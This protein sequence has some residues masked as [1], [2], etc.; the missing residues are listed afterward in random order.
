MTS[1][2]HLPP[3]SS[4]ATKAINHPLSAADQS[5]MA[6]IRKATAAGKGVIERAAFDAV[7]EQTPDAKGVGYETGV[8][9]G[10]SGVW[11]RPLNAAPHAVILYL[12]GGAYIAGT[13]NAFRH[14]SGQIAACTTVAAFV[15]DYRLAPEHHLPTALEDAKAVYSALTNDHANAVAIV[16]DSAGGGL[17]LVLLAVVRSAAEAGKATAPYAGAV[18]SPWTD[19]ALTGASMIERAEADPF[20][21]EAALASAAAQYLHGEDARSSLASPLYGELAGI[22]SLQLHVGTDEILFDDARRYAER[23]QSQHV[24]TTLHVWEGVPHVFQSNVGKLAAAQEALDVLG[25]FLRSHLPREE[26]RR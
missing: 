14:L 17:A 16:G 2:S 5:V 8:V 7:M 6:E 24:E 20:L 26:E 12:H 1:G 23:A 13:A 22:A 21:T 18:M 9:G 25:A 15:P 4:H 11:C 3:A 19:L 10:V